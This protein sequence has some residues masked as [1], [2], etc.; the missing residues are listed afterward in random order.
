MLC[1]LLTVWQNRRQK[2]FNR[3]LCSSAG[4]F[5][6]V[7]GGLDIIKW[8]KILLIYSVSRFSLGGLELCL[9]GLSSPKPPCADGSAVWTNI[10]SQKNN[11]LTYF[12]QINIIVLRYTW[13]H[14]VHNQRNEWVWSKTELISCCKSQKFPV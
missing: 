12:K 11:T 13:I 1:D 4:G 3:G 2:V 14:T 9:G 7:R 6:F 8:N 5:A 10:L